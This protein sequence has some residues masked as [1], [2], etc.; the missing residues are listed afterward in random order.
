MKTAF[1]C[2]NNVATPDNNSP[3]PDA[4]NSAHLTVNPAKT[5]AG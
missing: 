3:V 2:F 5:F 1:S 4:A